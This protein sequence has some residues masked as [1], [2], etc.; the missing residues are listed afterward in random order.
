MWEEQPIMQQTSFLAMIRDF[1]EFRI[2]ILALALP[3]EKPT[4][5]SQGTL[6]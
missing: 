4:Q 5:F 3:N 6:R 1:I 2:P